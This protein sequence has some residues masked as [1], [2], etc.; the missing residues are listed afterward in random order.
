MNAVPLKI[1]LK[2]LFITIPAILLANT[3]QANSGN[4]NL[5]GTVSAVTCNISVESVSG[6]A[7]TMVDLG[8]SAVDS[9]GQEVIFYLS[10]DVSDSNCDLTNLNADVT[11][12]G[13]NLGPQGI[14]NSSGTAEGTRAL[15]K[16][17]PLGGAAVDITSAQPSH[18]FLQS[19]MHQDGSLQFSAQLV[20][21]SE[22]GT[23]A[24]TVAY[25]VSYH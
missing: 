15:L 5:V 3:V 8:T 16:A 2:S 18:E 14:E 4:L 7:V 6:S 9:A 20:A 10:P 23:F 19:Q 13:S 22:P 11:W 25:S 12:S 21:G 1:G 17:R 24:S